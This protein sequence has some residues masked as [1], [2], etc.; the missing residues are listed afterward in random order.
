MGKQWRSHR[1]KKKQISSRIHGADRPY[2]NKEEG[3]QDGLFFVP[4]IQENIKKG[5]QLSLPQY[6]QARNRYPGV[7]AFVI[8]W[9][10]PR[11]R[12]LDGCSFCFASIIH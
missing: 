5:A 11:Q 2:K 12:I 6:I 9:S 8:D 4:Y 7:V 10:N 1:Q 3:D